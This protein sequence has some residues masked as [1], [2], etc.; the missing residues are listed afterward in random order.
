MKARPARGFTLI[1]SVIAAGLFVLVGL[2]TFAVF[3]YGMAAHSRG[4]I[5]TDAQK[6]A[7]EL[8]GRLTSDMQSAMALQ[9]P[10]ETDRTPRTSAVLTPSINVYSVDNDIAFTAPASQNVTTLNP[11]LDSGYVLV[12]YARPT[13]QK[14]KVY[15]RSYPYGLVSASQ[16]VAY[17]STSGA[18]SI[19]ATAIDNQYGAPGTNPATLQANDTGWQEVVSLGGPNDLVKFTLTHRNPNTSLPANQAPYDPNHFTISVSVVRYVQAPRT[20]ATDI[21]VSAASEAADRQNDRARKDLTTEITLQRF[22]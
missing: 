5:G 12:R 10:T 22:Q 1:E 14:N 17:D 13:G 19:N 3:K 21:D 11:S 16:Y 9:T 20:P 6:S 2:L 4:L 18:W 8:M 15:R 7:R